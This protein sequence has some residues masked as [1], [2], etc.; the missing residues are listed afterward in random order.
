M[1][2]E[3]LPMTDPWDASKC[4]AFGRNLFAEGKSAAREKR[5]CLRSRKFKAFMVAHGK[6]NLLPLIY[7][8]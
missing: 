5:L 4:N 3:A 8:D 6:P 2:Q 7:T 1:E